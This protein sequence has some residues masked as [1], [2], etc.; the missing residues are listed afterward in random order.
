M[1]ET[2]SVNV[3]TMREEEVEE[4]VRL[5]HATKIVAYPYLPLEQ[6]RTLAEDADFFRE[7]ILPHSEVWVAVSGD[8]P[9]G[10]LAMKDSYIDRLYVHPE[11]Q[12]RG[13]GTALLDTAM[14]RSPTG[15]QLHTH[16]A[17]TQARAFYEQ[18]GFQAIRFG[19]SPAPES[20][21]DVEYHW[22]P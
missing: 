18:R 10:F 5:W 13:V 6:R 16:Q 11:H 15:L 8:R 2:P 20:A 21:P 12:R 22:V 9:V 3:R 19:L 1:S 7:V 14:E 17:N 4:V